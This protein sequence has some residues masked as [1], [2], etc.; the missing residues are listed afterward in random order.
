MSLCS[1]VTMGLFCLPTLLILYRGLFLQVVLYNAQAWSNLSK[2]D[3]S[4]LQTVQLKF[5]KRMFHAPS[6]TSNPLTYLETGLLPI[7]QEIHIR[8]LTYLHH[9]VGLEEDDPVLSAYTEQ[10]KYKYA[11]NWGNDVKILR[12]KY[13]INQTDEEVKS[14][15]KRRWKK[16]VKTTI[17]ASTLNQLS[18]EARKQKRASN[19]LPYNEFK[20]QKY[21]SNFPTPLARK[22]FHAR[23]GILDIKGLRTYK[24][25]ND[26]KCRLCEGDDENVD[27]IVNICPS[28]SR[29]NLIQSVYTNNE[30]EMKEV[31]RR[32]QEF[33]NKVDDPDLSS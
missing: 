1:D 11:P 25:G 28:I 23:L 15:S 2:Q 18:E 32:C 27:H 20:T 8:Q 13:G 16:I 4:N 7:E 19:L 24:Y 17:T 22:L 12:S 9:I 10:I 6:S 26:L 31:A 30:E 14:M 5:I 21:I 3:I 29:T 33:C